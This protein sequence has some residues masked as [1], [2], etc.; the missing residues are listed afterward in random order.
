M[1]L[2][3]GGGSEVKGREK[4]TS[5]RSE[6]GGESMFSFFSLHLICSLLPKRDE[7]LCNLAEIRKP[8]ARF[9]IWVDKGCFFVLEELS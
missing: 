5:V 4:Q 3:I 2:V 7:E 1:P 9:S 8:T 6:D